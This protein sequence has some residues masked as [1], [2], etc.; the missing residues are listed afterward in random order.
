MYT[1]LIGVR[2]L[3]T[4]REQYGIAIIRGPIIADYSLGQR[5]DTVTVNISHDH[6]CLLKRLR[7]HVHRKICFSPV[8][9]ILLASVKMSNHVA[10]S[11]AQQCKLSINLLISLFRTTKMAH[12]WVVRV[13]R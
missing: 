2:K 4:I 13:P 3:D 8:D 5:P 1:V 7:S 10:S 12:L 6:V 9:G 11:R